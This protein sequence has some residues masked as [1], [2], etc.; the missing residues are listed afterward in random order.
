MLINLLIQRVK[1]KKIVSVRKL[2]VKYILIC[3]RFI[4]ISTNWK[5]KQD[6]KRKMMKNEENNL[7][8]IINNLKNKLKF[9]KY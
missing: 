8:K 7:K 6:L 3:K 9:K 1:L 5:S 4:Q 2:L